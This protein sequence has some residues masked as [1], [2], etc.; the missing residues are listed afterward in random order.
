MA[1]VSSPDRF[2]ITDGSGNTKLDTS[3]KYPVIHSN[4]SG[5]VTNIAIV[6]GSSYGDNIVTDTYYF[7]S[8]EGGGY[9]TSGASE[10]RYVTPTVESYQTLWTA[11]AGVYIDCVIAKIK[12]TAISSA[13]PPAA[14]SPGATA[15]KNTLRSTMFTQS[16]TVGTWYAMNGSLLVEMLVAQNGKVQ[17]AATCAIYV[18]AS[19]TKVMFYFKRTGYNDDSSTSVN[20]GFDYQASIIRII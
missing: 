20:F 13:A 9:G 6:G 7:P 3:D 11:P 8:R 15:A 5:S 14:S 2:L 4:I 12:P 1:F 10:T 17:R 19:R 18:D 16:L